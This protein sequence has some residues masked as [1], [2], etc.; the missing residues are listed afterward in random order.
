MKAKINFKTYLS[1][2][3]RQNKIFYCFI[4]AIKMGTLNTINCLTYLQEFF[5]SF[6]LELKIALN[7]CYIAALIQIYCWNLMKILD[8]RSFTLKKFFFLHLNNFTVLPRLIIVCSVIQRSTCLVNKGRRYIQPSCKPSAI[9]KDLHIYFC[10][11][12]SVSTDF[13][14]M[15]P[16]VCNG[17]STQRIFLSI[18]NLIFI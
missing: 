6:E 15:T 8:W 13:P 7:D 12:P 11:H 16:S 4:P 2:L 17:T 14:T 10:R 18:L 9:L 1:Y 5:I 3:L